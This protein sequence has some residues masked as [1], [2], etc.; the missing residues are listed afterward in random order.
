V[1]VGIGA[2]CRTSLARPGS[3]ASHATARAIATP[4]ASS[5]ARSAH[6][7]LVA[8]SWRHGEQSTFRAGRHSNLRAR[9]ARHHSAGIF[10]AT[11]VRGRCQARSCI[12]RCSQARS[13]S[14]ESRAGRTGTSSNRGRRRHNV[15]CQ[16]SSAV[17]SCGSAG[18]SSAPAPSCERG[19]RW[20][21]ARIS[22]IRRGCST[23]WSS[24]ASVQTDC[25]RRS[26]DI[27]SE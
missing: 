23:G 15:I 27:R 10:P 24:R 22:N 6:A 12:K 9:L 26:H 8:T 2:A 11:A 1:S 4:D 19:W 17:C 20:N 25:W 21:N 13:F 5:S 18:L 3:S 14:P 7:W 16:Q